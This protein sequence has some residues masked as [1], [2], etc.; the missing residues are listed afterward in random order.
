FGNRDPQYHTAL[1]TCPVR[2]EGD[3]GWIETGD[4][5][6]FEVRPESLRKFF[7]I[8]VLARRARTSMPKNLAQ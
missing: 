4:A 1:G 7:G 8:D 5:G 6:L 3:E 2:F